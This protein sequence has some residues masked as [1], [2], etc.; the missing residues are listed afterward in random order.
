MSDA[1]SQKQ[2]IERVDGDFDPERKQALT[3]FALMP[4]A[5]AS[6]NDRDLPLLSSIDS[7][8]PPALDLPDLPPARA[9]ASDSNLSDCPGLVSAS[10]SASLST[11]SASDDE[12][13]LSRSRRESIEYHYAAYYRHR[14][15]LNEARELDE[16]R[17]VELVI[18]TGVPGHTHASIDAAFFDVTA[19]FDDADRHKR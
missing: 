14:A 8:S 6:A 15:E 1:S 13:P 16:A 7:D 9:S 12:Q 11:P 19:F 3:P 4:P 18:G 5:P 17:E 10:D 2:I